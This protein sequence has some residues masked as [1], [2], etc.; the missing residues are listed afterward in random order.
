MWY[1]SDSENDASKPLEKLIEQEPTRLAKYPAHIPNLA[2]PTIDILCI[3]KDVN[4][5]T[6]PSKTYVN[7]GEQYQ[8]HVLKRYCIVITKPTSLIHPHGFYKHEWH[9]RLK[10]FRKVEKHRF[11]ENTDQDTIKTV[12]FETKVCINIYNIYNCH[13]EFCW[14]RTGQKRTGR[15]TFSNVVELHVPKKKKRKSR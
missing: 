11:I 3:L 8:F 13:V 12:H 5:K 2:I 7:N 4:M 9:I 15:E 14:D 10:Q 1:F 6:A